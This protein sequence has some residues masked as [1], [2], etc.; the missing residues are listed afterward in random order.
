M[1]DV[2]VLFN[3]SFHICSV[4]CSRLPVDVVIASVASVERGN[5]VNINRHEKKKLIQV[6][7][8]MMRMI[9]FLPSFLLPLQLSISNL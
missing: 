1:I 5:V 6:T 2:E 9:S 8:L 3:R 4:G 7:E